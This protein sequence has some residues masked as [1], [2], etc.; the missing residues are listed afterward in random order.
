[1]EGMTVQEATQVSEVLHLLG[2]FLLV[3]SGFAFFIVAKR[4]SFGFFVLGG[5]LHRDRLTL[6]KGV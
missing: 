1:M 2:T 5:C 4:L 3:A 6:A